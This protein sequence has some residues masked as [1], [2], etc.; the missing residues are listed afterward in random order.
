VLQLTRG[1]NNQTPVRIIVAAFL[2][3]FCCVV[4][5]LISKNYQEVLGDKVHLSRTAVH[6][7]LIPFVF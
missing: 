1:G 7:I 3:V 6:V 2:I 5:V 4:G